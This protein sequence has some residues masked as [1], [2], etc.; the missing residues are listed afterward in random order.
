ML[1]LKIGSAASSGD[2]GKLT[3]LVPPWSL[4]ETD[5]LILRFCI[6]LTSAQKRFFR[7]YSLLIIRYSP[8]EITQ[9]Q[10]QVSTIFNVY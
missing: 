1:R 5:L 4:F 9:D 10:V 6:L 8:K 7:I 2:Q 3:F